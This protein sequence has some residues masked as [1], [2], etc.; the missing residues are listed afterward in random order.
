MRAQERAQSVCARACSFCL[1]ARAR[2][3]FV[4]VCARVRVYVC[5]CVCMY[6]CVC[7]R[8]RECVCVCVCVCVRACVR[9]MCYVRHALARLDNEIMIVSAAV[10]LTV[11]ALLTA[12]QSV[13]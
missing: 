8:A 6:V 11:L 1:H 7:A 3:C 13:A 2:E 12:G 5:M 9:A 4:C 10:V